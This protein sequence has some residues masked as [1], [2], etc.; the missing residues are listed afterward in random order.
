ML[1]SLMRFT[2]LAGQERNDRKQYNPEVKGNYL[3]I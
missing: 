3:Y 1:H 2:N